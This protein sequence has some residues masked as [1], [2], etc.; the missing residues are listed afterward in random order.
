[1]FFDFI[2][3]TAITSGSII[4]MEK[5]APDC[6]VPASTCCLFLNSR[7]G[8]FLKSSGKR[9]GGVRL[10]LIDCRNGNAVGTEK[11]VSAA[12]LWVPLYS[13]CKKPIPNIMWFRHCRQINYTWNYR[14][15]Q[16]SNILNPFYMQVF[17]FLFCFMRL[18]RILSFSTWWNN[19]YSVVTCCIGYRYIKN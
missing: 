8:K 7:R 5:K 12:V 3:N 18:L 1:M 11:C 19:L 9:N 13:F 16:R 6:R 15:Y 10:N 17:R 4:C 14:L 2:C